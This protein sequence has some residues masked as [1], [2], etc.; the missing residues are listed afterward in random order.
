MTAQWYS[1]LTDTT[2]Q[3][4]GP[5]VDW[6]FCFTLVSVFCSIFHLTEE[7]VSSNSLKT[8]ILSEIKNILPESWS[9][10]SMSY[11]MHTI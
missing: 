11:L 6:A 2:V 4:F 8:V 5:T 3:I 7:V 9:I 10:G 1:L